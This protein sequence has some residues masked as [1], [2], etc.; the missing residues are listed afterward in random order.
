MDTKNLTSQYA[1][2]H[3]EP[4]QNPLGSSASLEQEARSKRQKA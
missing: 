2:G 4:K 1:K 3:E